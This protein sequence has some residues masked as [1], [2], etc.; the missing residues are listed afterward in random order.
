MVSTGPVGGTCGSGVVF[1]SCVDECGACD[2]KSW[3]SM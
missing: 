1:S 2:E 3:W